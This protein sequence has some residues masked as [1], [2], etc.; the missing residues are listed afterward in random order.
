MYITGENVDEL[1]TSRCPGYMSSL[2][3]R[4]DRRTS[5][6]VA[7]LKGTAKAE[8]AQTNGA[9]TETG[10]LNDIDDS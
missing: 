7:E 5:R 4:R 9:W 8:A 6:N 10:E 3:K 1:G 2:R